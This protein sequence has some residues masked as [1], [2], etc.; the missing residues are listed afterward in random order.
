MNTYRVGIGNG[1]K[2][3]EVRA[4]RFVLDAA[5]ITFWSGGEVTGFFPVDSVCSVVRIEA[6]KD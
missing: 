3:M 1:V 2:S 6:G 5:A 4:E